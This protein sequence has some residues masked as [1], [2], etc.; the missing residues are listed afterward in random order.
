MNKNYHIGIDLGGTNVAGGIVDE[1]YRI[2]AKDSLKTPKNEGYMAVADKICELCRILLDKAECEFSDIKSVGVGSPGSIDSKRGYIEFSANLDFTDVEFGKILEEKLN[3]KYNMSEHTVPVHIENDANAAAYGEFIAGAGAGT[4]NMVMVTLGTGIGGGIIINKK[5]YSGFT[6][7]GGEVGHMVI[8]RN[9]KKCN[10]GRNGCWE[11]YGS[12]TGLVSLTKEKMEQNH[13]SLM[14]KNYEE[15]GKIN[16]R[17]A[18]DCMRLGDETAREVIKE[19]TD[20]L[21]LGIMNLINILQP[22]V[23]VIG[24]GISNEG[25]YLLEPIREYINREKYTKLESNDTKIC[26][27]KLNNDAGIIGAAFL[28]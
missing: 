6:Y 12:A 11:V 20:Y 5:I 4:E 27:A 14:W 17:T 13:N 16:G 7:A 3:K 8:E 24:G 25:E 10:C 15:K 28:G 1:G 9:G 2:I 18:F 21:G 23:I 26:A 22:E 19:Y